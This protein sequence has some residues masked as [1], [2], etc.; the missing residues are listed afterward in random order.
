[1]SLHPRHRSQ[2]AAEQGLL[3]QPLVLPAS[4]CQA[5]NNGFAPSCCTHRCESRNKLHPC[6]TRIFMVLLVEEQ[7]ARPYG[8]FS[9]ATQQVMPAKSC[10]VVRN[11][12]SAGSPAIACSNIVF[13]LPKISPPFPIPQAPHS[14]CLP[15]FLLIYLCSLENGI[16]D[17]SE[18]VRALPARR[19]LYQ[20]C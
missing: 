10:T 6:S 19:R 20:R 14:P 18:Q 7:Q 9:L 15:L 3:H 2:G 13:L 5:G 17:V 4:A 8:D 12:V 1:M 16:L 11:L